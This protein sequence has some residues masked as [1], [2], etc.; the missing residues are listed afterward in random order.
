[1]VLSIEADLSIT[2]QH[3]LFTCAVQTVSSGSMMMD[4]NMK[5]RDCDHTCP[6]QSRDLM[7]HIHVLEMHD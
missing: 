7:H 2:Q 5:V 1:M 6:A 3:I 4:C